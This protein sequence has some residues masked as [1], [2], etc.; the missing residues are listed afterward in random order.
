MRSSFVHTS[1]S[2]VSFCCNQ[3]AVQQV[4]ATVW[5]ITVSRN[6]PGTVRADAEV[7]TR[8]GCGCT[9][10]LKKEGIRVGLLG[11]DL[12]QIQLSYR[13]A[14]RTASE[15]WQPQVTSLETP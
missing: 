14:E 12:S 2:G 15:Y 4:F 13:Y 1:F 8:A 10:L 3:H 6:L 5:L 7:Q 9:M 11:A